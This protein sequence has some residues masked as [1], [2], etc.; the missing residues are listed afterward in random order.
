MCGLTCGQESDWDGEVIQPDQ[1]KLD[2]ILASMSILL[3]EMIRFLIC[4][5]LTKE[6]VQIDLIRE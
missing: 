1:M 4:V 5:E 3:T 2:S 6:F